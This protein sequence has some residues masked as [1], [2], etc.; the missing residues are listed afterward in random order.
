MTAHDLAVT[1][2]G[3][4]T[5]RPAD[6]Q[7]RTL[8]TFGLLGYMDEAEIPILAAVLRDSALITQTPHE[9][10]LA[11]APAGLAALAA[12]SMRDFP[13]VIQNF[14]RLRFP[15]A[16]TTGEPWMPGQTDSPS[17]S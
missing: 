7:W 14:M 12:R 8:S 3:H 16:V 13:P 5:D 17:P 6:A 2:T 4:T 11:L 9:A 1:L 15:N 10:H